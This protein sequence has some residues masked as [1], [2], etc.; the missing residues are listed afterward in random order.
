MKKTKTHQIK[1]KQP[2][3][4]PSPRRTKKNQQKKTRTKKNMKANQ[5]VKRQ[6]KYVSRENSERDSDKEHKQTRKDLK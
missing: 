2:T 4:I 6:K 1:P 5:Y 3:Q